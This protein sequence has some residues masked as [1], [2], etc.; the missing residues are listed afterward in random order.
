MIEVDLIGLLYPFFMILFIF[1]VIYSLLNKFNLFSSSENKSSSLIN[2]LI[3]LGVSIFVYST[4]F[5]Q[6]TVRDL[7]SYFALLVVIAFFIVLFFVMFGFEQNELKNSFFSDESTTGTFLFIVVLVIIVISIASSIGQDLL[8]Q[9]IKTDADAGQI[10]VKFP[11][12]GNN[13]ENAQVI[14]EDRTYIEINDESTYIVT[15]ESTEFE[16][17]VFDTLFDKDVLGMIVFFISAAIII[18]SLGT[19]HDKL[20]GIN[21][22]LNDKKK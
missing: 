4:P 8:N 15:E 6:R 7:S 19:K 22:L 1:A 9:D 17:N 13:E 18:L 16:R 21:K 12:I 2:G 3:A 14:K 10:N 5:V 11:Q 20:S